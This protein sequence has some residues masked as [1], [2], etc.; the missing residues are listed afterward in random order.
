M[1][2]PG[3]LE[4]DTPMHAHRTPWAGPARAPGH[5]P[6]SLEDGTPAVPDAAV[7]CRGVTKAYG[8]GEEGIQ[9]LRGVDLDVFPGQLTML[10]GPSGC[11]KTTLVSIITGIL[12]ADAGSCRVYG[13]DVS[14]MDDAA[15]TRFRRESVGFVFQAFHLLPALPAWE[16]VAL[17]L[18]IAGVD[19]REAQARAR[20]TLR[21]V[22]LGERAGAL[23]GAL[24]GGQQ[25]RIAIGRALVH[26]PRL[27]VCD[28]P[29]SNLDA[30]TGH[31]IVDLLRD[32]ARA[33]GRAI[34]VVTHDPRILGEADRIA[35]MEDGRI[36]G[37]E[38]AAGPAA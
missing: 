37:V 21:L 14:R 8:R 36:V 16:N 27:V 15:R 20:E 13:Q 9:A 11:G 12:Q 23:P 35:R 19:R 32:A 24:S 1:R 18:L 26:G 10:M 38:A 5:Q 2:F 25:Q 33:P 3:P 7:Q 29:T 22:G 30:R 31:A 28:E 34:V 6:P 4:D 17:P